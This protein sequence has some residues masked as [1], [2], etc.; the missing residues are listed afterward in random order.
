MSEFREFPPISSNLTVS[1]GTNQKGRQMPRRHNGL[2]SGPSEVKPVQIV[3]KKGKRTVAINGVP[4]KGCVP[5]SDGDVVDAFTSTELSEDA[6]VDLDLLADGHIDQED[7]EAMG[8]ETAIE[9]L[10][11][12]GSRNVF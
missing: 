2:T 3:R 8:D 12:I 6:Q 9:A 11:F 4:I 10:D 5:T 1:H 7:L